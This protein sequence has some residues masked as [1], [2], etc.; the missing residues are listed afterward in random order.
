MKT[1]IY[2]IES[3]N[4]LLDATTI[5]CIGVKVNDEET[6]VFTSRPIRGSSGSIT[7]CIELLLTADRLV[8][9]NIV[10]F[11]NSVIRKIRGI[12]LFT[13][14][15][16]FDTLIASQLRYPNMILID[17]NNKSLDSKLKGSHSL[18]AW[19]QRLGDAKDHHEDW[20]KLS[21]EMVEYCRQDV[22]VTSLLYKKLNNTIPDEAMRLEQKFAYIIARQEEKGVLFDVKKAQELH[23]ELV[24]ELDIAIKELYKV[25]IPLK[26]F[27]KM[28]EVNKV[29]KD[30]KDNKNYLK[31]IEKGGCYN[32]NMEWGYWTDVIFN[33]NSGAHIVRWV[34]YLYGK[35]K[36][37]LT[38]KGSPKAG[39]EDLL[40]MF[41]DKEWAKPLT[42]YLEV[43]KLMGQLAE[44]NNAWLKLVRDDNRIHGEVNTLGAVSRR[45]TH[46]KP[47]LAQVPSSRA[48]KGHECRALFT[49]PNGY[50]L[51]G[52][53]ADA[54]EL[55]T[56]SH[57][58]ARHDGGKYARIVDSGDKDKGTDIHTVNQRAAGLPTRDD[59][60]T[61]IYALCYGAG[62]EKLGSIIGGT[63][64]EGNKIKTKFFKAIP[65]LK[66][67][68]EGVGQAVKKNG[69]L[70]ALDGNRYFIRSEHS[71]LNTLLQ[72]A[73]ALVIK[74]WNCEVYDRAIERGW[75]WGKD[76]A[77]VLSIHDEAQWEVSEDITD[78]F[79]KLTEESFTMIT[80]TLGFRIPLKGNAKIGTNWSETH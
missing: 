68:T 23:I 71:A 35:Q 33:P 67:L 32:E 20:S 27:I 24:S 46:N 31:Q 45:C 3:D 18:K 36:W 54:L 75:V 16:H 55:R 57:Y 52:C 42:H 62:A 37:E 47:N 69:Y 72:G 80:E 12:D 8:G 76:F 59:A 1:I 58:M 39:S 6:Q 28:N 65:A 40:R 66:E 26:D 13:T 48:Y 14:I 7:E 9:H 61:F 11:D 43:K 30:G 44:G 34:E 73:G 38:E 53:D 77:Q 64:K 70:L 19:G 17:S 41:S 29:N 49:V 78:E 5:H 51:V 79:A 22:E 50:K 21:E 60:K 4:L 2:D 56:L 10:K 15:E 63:A 74:Y 25:F